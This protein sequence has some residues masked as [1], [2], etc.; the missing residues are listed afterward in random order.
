[1]VEAIEESSPEQRR[2]SITTDTETVQYGSPAISGRIK[3]KELDL[4]KMNNSTGDPNH[5]YMINL[6]QM[7]PLLKSQQYE[8]SEMAPEST[9]QNDR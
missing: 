5:K 8:D 2:K 4:N 3:N 6:K 9:M 7:E 1:M